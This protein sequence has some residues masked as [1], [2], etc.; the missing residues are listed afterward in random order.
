MRA[1][2]VGRLA[3]GRGAR[4]STSASLSLLRFSINCNAGTFPLISVLT[5]ATNATDEPLPFCNGSTLQALTAHSNCQSGAPPLHALATQSNCQSGVTPLHALAA[6]SSC[7]SGMHC[8]G[9]HARHMRGPKTQTRIACVR[10]V[11]LRT[12]E[13]I[14]PY[15]PLSIGAGGWVFESCVRV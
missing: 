15:L 5:S 9:K 11:K 2:C 4:L 7:Q 8:A 1:A 3:G 14:A 12:Q 10:S 13:T 6:H